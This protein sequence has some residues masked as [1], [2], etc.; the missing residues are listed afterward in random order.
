M[1]QIFSEYFD[2]L[3]HSFHRLL[4]THHHSSS[5]AGTVDKIVADVP[6]GLNFTPPTRMTGCEG[7]RLMQNLNT[8]TISV[9]ACMG[10]IKNLF[11]IF[12]T[13]LKGV[14]V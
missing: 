1:E 13:K 5:V 2:F 10:N 4:H 12:G 11:Y 14:P 3:C 8:R 6:S 7:K 9:V